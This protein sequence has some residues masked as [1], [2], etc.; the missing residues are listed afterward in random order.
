MTKQL[1]RNL[2]LG[3]I[4]CLAIAGCASDADDANPVDEVTTAEQEITTQICTPGQETCDI[5]CFYDGGPSTDDCIIK[6]NATGTNWVTIASCGWA[7]NFPFSASCLN[8]QPHPV[9]KN[10]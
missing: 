6:C 10:N 1:S 5:G 8:S 7:Q 4:T 9:C 2:F 3:L